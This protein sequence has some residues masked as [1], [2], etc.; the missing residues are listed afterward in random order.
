M[1]DTLSTLSGGALNQLISI[2]SLSIGGRNKTGIEH[3]VVVVGE[4]SIP[5]DPAILRGIVNQLVAHTKIGP[6]ERSVVTKIVRDVILHPPVKRFESE[7][8]H[9]EQALE[10]TIAFFEACFDKA[11][12]GGSVALPSV[13]Q[14]NR[15]P[16]RQHSRRDTRSS[17]VERVREVPTLTPEAENNIKS[18]NIPPAKQLDL[19]NAFITKVDAIPDLADESKAAVAKMKQAHESGSKRYSGYAFGLLIGSGNTGVIDNLVCAGLKYSKENIGDR[20]ELYDHL[21]QPERSKLYWAASDVMSS[22]VQEEFA[23]TGGKTSPTRY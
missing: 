6:L 4:Q 1:T 3:P 2:A 23:R 15:I 9:A 13:P 17:A 8:S 10:P 11:A 21:P 18:A 16:T 5:V 20:D 22:Y 14:G 19:L 7:Q 12:L